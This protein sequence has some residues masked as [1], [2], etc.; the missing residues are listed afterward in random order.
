MPLLIPQQKRNVPDVG[1][2]IYVEDMTSWNMK[3]WESFSLASSKGWALR[4]AGES[5]VRPSARSYLT[6]SSVNFVYNSKLDLQE[7]FEERHGFDG[8]SSPWQTIEATRAKQV[9]MVPSS[10]VTQTSALPESPSTGTK[11][12][13][14]IQS[15]IASVICGTTLPFL[16]HHCLVKFSQWSCCCLVSIWRPESARNYQDSNLPHHHSPKQKPPH[17]RKVTYFRNP[18]SSNHL[19]KEVISEFSKSNRRKTLNRQPNTNTR[20]HHELQPK[21]Q[22][23][24]A[25]GISILI[26]D[27]MHFR[28]IRWL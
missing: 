12:T 15:W 13:R 20:S 28:T 14:P 27:H 25:L 23:I 10:S 16:L 18:C 24:F 26:E 21:S 5:G 11:A 22:Q 1:D 4:Q 6:L 3:T 19:S 17:V 2:I 9:L 7:S 8:T